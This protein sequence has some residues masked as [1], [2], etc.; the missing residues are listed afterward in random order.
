[1][2][3][4]NGWFWRFFVRAA[5][6]LLAFGGGLYVA[7][8]GVFPW[9]R[10]SQGASVARDMVRAVRA[11]KPLLQDWERANVASGAVD[12]RHLVLAEGSELA[13]AATATGGGWHFGEHCPAAR[14]CLAVEY[15]P[16]G[17]VV[18]SWPFRPPP[19][20]E[21]MPAAQVEGTFG[22]DG[23]EAMDAAH[24]ARYS[25]GDLL[26][27]FRYLDF[28][29][30]ADAGVARIGGSGHALWYRRDYSRGEPLVAAGDTALVVGT[31]RTG[32]WAA[33]TQGI[34]GRAC[35][36]GEATLDVVQILDG[37]G[38]LVEQVSAAGALLASRWAPELQRA[39]PCRPVHVSSVSLV[40]DDV[41]GLDGARPGDLVLSFRDLD[42]LAILD[43]ETYEMKRY[44]RGTFQR[45][46]SVKHWRGPEFVVFDGR[47]GMTRARG[48]LRFHSRVL[49]VDVES[50][51]E[52]VVFPRDPER[53]G[54]RARDG[55]RISISPDRTRLIASFRGVG[56]AVEVR[57][58]D[59]AVLAQFDHL[60]RM[61]GHPSFG[62]AGVVAR[63]ANA[64][65]FY[66]DEALR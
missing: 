58:E 23:E 17:E 21:A 49:L 56:R 14:G 10:F 44:V 3:R 31:R 8:A 37:Q 61:A 1:M 42:A 9:G 54:W 57:V 47:G 19:V 11:D 39:N 12:G 33:Q 30:P 53:F 15:S 43:R 20:A 7:W 65:V 62:A 22:I 18:R 2:A 64:G 55:G 24:V 16:G 4:R 5:V 25:N 46:H 51:A 32:G 52:T 29:F 35:E 38:R 41:A 66:S 34:P 28:H 60:H 63:F 50:G 27:V 59:G 13:G 6:V 36:G 45:P 40:G 48:D 26:V